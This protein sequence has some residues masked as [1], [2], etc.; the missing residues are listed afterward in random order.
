MP[1]AAVLGTA[2]AVAALTV[3]GCDSSTK[4]HVQAAD[5]GN[6]AACA[7]G[8]CEI[9]VPAGTAIAVPRS[10]AVQDLTL[11]EVTA[12]RITI[13]AHDIGT[14]S[15]GT[16]SG[17]CHSST[18]NG[19]LTATMGEDA[20]ITENGLSLVVESMDGDTAVLKIEPTG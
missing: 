17:Q 12:D 11:T 3:A 9:A 7:D 18:D 6:V 16:C 2:V 1:Y 8:Q 5:G 20:H 15:N 14:T 10:M 4:G 13:T 19:A